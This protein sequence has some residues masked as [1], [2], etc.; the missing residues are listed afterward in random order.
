MQLRK[1]I[2]ERPD[3]IDYVTPLITTH[4]REVVEENLK[5]VARLQVVKQDLDRYACPE[6]HRG[7]AVSFGVDGDELCVHGVPQRL[8]VSAV[9]RKRWNARPD[10]VMPVVCMKDHFARKFA[11]KT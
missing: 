8:A 4:R 11:C 6:K 5:R 7:S 3:P 2:I 9:Y 10:V 1:C